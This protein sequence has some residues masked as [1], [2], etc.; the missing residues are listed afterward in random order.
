MKKIPVLNFFGFAGEL[1]HFNS[2][3]NI[4]NNNKAIV[5]NCQQIYECTDIMA[6]IRTSSFEIEIWGNN[7]KL[8]NYAQGSV[9]ITGTIEQINLAS[10]K[11]LEKNN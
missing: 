8:S 2:Y 3:I 9:E 5:E 10:K 11:I 4:V 6:K 1:L 7:L